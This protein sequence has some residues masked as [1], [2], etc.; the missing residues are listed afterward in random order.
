MISKMPY[1]LFRIGRSFATVIRSVPG[2][3]PPIRE[4]TVAGR[5]AGIL[6]S[7]GSKNEQLDTIN[8]DMEF[9]QKLLQEVDPLHPEP[10][11]SKLYRE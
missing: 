2:N 5:Y 9:I 11:N 1:Q 6:F 3:R 7:L 10:Q 4:E 8:E